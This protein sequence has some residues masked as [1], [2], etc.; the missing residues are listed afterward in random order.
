MSLADLH[1]H[2]TA[3]DGELSPSDVV[4]KAASIGLSAIALTDHDTM[5]GLVE[6][7]AAG[8]LHGVRV[9][10]GIEL[11]TEFG[12][13]E[14]HILGYFIQPNRGILQ[15]KLEQLREARCQRALEILRRLQNI[16]LSISW[17]QVLNHL[18]GRVVGRPHVARALVE[19]GYVQSVQEAFEC[20]LER[21]RPAYVPRYKLSPQDAISL[22]H[23]SGGV[24]VLAHPGLLPDP[25]YLDT[26]LNLDWQ[27]IETSHPDHSDEVKL[28]LRNIAR[29]NNL[30]ATGGSDFHGCSRS[31]HGLGACGVDEKVVDALR[32]SCRF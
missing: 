30:I 29:A 25:S 14:I 21:G 4:A 1:V 11:S 26:L 10:P 16:G 22:I 19:A 13:T 17:S 32:S 7:Q 6:A 23:Q 20:Y 27:G 3:S 31:Y 12:D 28:N 8:S 24:T 9:V 15:S 5:D 18:E 2:S